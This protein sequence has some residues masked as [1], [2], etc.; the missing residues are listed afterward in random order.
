MHIL[1]TAGSSVTSVLKNYTIERPKEDLFDWQS[2]YHIGKMHYT[3]R[4]SV[5]VLK[6]NN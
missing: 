4:E 1:K 3:Y 5:E 2:Q 6:M